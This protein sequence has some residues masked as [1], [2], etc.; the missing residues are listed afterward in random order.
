[1]HIRSKQ[2]QK[3]RRPPQPIRRRARAQL[4]PKRSDMTSEVRHADAG[5]AGYNEL[6][7]M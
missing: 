4:R 6:K 1:M 2:M 5:V 3:R 7:G